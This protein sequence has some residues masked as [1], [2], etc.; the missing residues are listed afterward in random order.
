MKPIPASRMH[1]STASGGMPTLTPSTPSVSAAPDR[2]D[3]ARLPCLATGAPQAATI[4]AASVETLYDPELSP[5]V[6]TT[7]IASAG[8]STR[9][10]LARIAST[11]PVISSTLSPRVRKAMRKPPICAGVTS[12]ESMASK[13][14][15]A[16]AR[17]SAAPVAT[18]AI[19]G[20][21]ASIPLSDFSGGASG[22]EGAGEIEKI[23]QHDAAMLG[24]NAL[25]VELHAVNRRRAMRETHDQAVL[26]LGGDFEFRRRRFA[27]DD[28]RVI[29]R[30]LERAVDAAKHAASIMRNARQL[31]MHGQGRADDLGAE[32]LADRLMAETDA[33]DRRGRARPAN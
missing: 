13:A 7:S 14:E 27:V 17:V 20:L 28:Q 6:P 9:S 16:S 1:R 10:I 26:G 24:E 19:S 18:L 33:E 11:A 3:K 4:R 21:K 32:R 29:A 5:P 15:T 30:R 2:D 22:V 31:A 25:R 12:P 23:A 8:A